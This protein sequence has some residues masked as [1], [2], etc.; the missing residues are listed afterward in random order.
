MGPKRDEEEKEP[1]RDPAGNPQVFVTDD[2]VAGVSEAGNE[3]I[4]T[5]G[6]DQPDDE[7]DP[8]DHACR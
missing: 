4:D 5:D 2:D 7:P 6:D 8:S 3:A 1:L